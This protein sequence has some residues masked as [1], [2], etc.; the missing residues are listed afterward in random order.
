[1]E[2]GDEI[3][4]CSR[5]SRMLRFVKLRKLCFHLSDIQKWPA[6]LKWAGPQILWLES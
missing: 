1:M 3:Q 4:S 2:A 5:S 6:L